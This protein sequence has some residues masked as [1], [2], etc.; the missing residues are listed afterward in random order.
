MKIRILMPTIGAIMLLV[1]GAGNA[2][3]GQNAFRSVSG[4]TVFPSAAFGCAGDTV[5]YTTHYQGKPFAG[6]LWVKSP[7]GLNCEGG[8]G[9]VVQGYFEEWSQDGG[10]WCQGQLKL[11]LLPLPNGSYAQWSNIKAIPGYRCAGVGTAP[12]L[13]LRYTAH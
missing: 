9:R 12:K 7:A 3:A 4:D 5:H 10:D 13:P 1:V 2:L 11:Y 6:T 8:R